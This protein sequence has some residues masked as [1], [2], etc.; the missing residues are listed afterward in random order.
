MIPDV[1]A[2]TSGGPAPQ[3]SHVGTSFLDQEV[4]LPGFA[5]VPPWQGA[6][7][8]SLL[9]LVIGMDTEHHF[10]SNF[11]NPGAVFPCVVHF[12]LRGEDGGGEASFSDFCHIF[13]AS[14]DGERGYT[15][16]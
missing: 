15:G 5:C 11:R 12:P 3:L 16:A 2:L 10:G 4:S 1:P 13:L 6:V 8:I 7:T 14:C 9:G